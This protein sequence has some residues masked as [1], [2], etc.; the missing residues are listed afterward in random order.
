MR[1]VRHAM[2]DCE[3]GFAL[4]D[5]GCAMCDV[6]CAM[7]MW[8]AWEPGAGSA[9]STARWPPGSSN[10]TSSTRYPSRTPC[11]LA[12]RPCLSSVDLS[13]WLP[14][15]LGDCLLVYPPAQPQG[16]LSTCRRSCSAQSPTH[17]LPAVLP[18]SFPTHRNW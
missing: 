12:S 6:R 1:P 15:C 8:D 14:L 18:S 13:T 2:C 9:K 4:C 16:Y 5:V 7:L 17:F 3:A 11:L 10:S